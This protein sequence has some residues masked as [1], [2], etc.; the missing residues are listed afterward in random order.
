MCY[1]KTTLYRIKKSEKKKQTKVVRYWMRFEACVFIFINK[2]SF[3]AC[4]F[5]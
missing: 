4:H 2:L 3:R 5:R 1:E